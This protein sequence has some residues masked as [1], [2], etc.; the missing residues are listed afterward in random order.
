MLSLKKNFSWTILGNVIYAICQWGM[1]VVL[2]K[3][4]SA[5][6]VGQFTLALAV[7]APVIMI[8]NMQLRGVQATDAKNKYLLSDYMAVRLFSSI[9]AVC[10]IVLILHFG[11]FDKAVFLVIYILLLAKFMESFSDVF[12]G[13]FQQHEKMS[14]I[15]K[16]MIIKGIFSVLVMAVV[17]YFSSSLPWALFGIL[18]SWTLGLVFYDWR[19]SRYL[20]N[21]TG[22][23]D[24]GSLITM[25]FLSLLRRRRVLFR[26][27][28]LAFPLGVVMGVISLNSNIPRYAIEKYLGIRDL[29][30]FAALSYAVIA[31]SM[32]MQALGQT[33]TP[34]MARYFSD[35]DM[36]S[37]QK[38][39]RKMVSVNFAIG[40]LGV[41]VILFYGEEVLLFIYT[42]EYAVFSNLFTVLMIS[43]T[44]SGVA[45]ALGYAM[46]A[47]RQF[48]VQIPLFLVVL[49]S[50]FLSSLFLIP[51]FKL[52]GAAMALIIS[53][54]IQIIGGVFIIRKAMRI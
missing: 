43:A 24:G 49:M 5:E 53:A 54:F 3:L 21:V 19:M 13:F 33:V 6:I 32:F 27:I 48:N 14:L 2:A 50:T 22:C 40:L 46:T 29:G 1:L 25:L 30:I 12:Y 10:I 17:F 28:A 16:S 52:Y 9:V 8:T 18:C 39:L 47:A 51:H 11:H 44:L 26:I 38:L 15:A 20:L 23:S 7:I 4:G 35:H 36:L 45:S 37:F 41:L 42:P 31:V 34:R